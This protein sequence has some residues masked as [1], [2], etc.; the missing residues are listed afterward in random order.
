MF[1]GSPRLGQIRASFVNEAEPLSETVLASRPPFT[2]IMMPMISRPSPRALLSF[3]LAVLGCATR[4]SAVEIVAH[5]GASADA[6][7]NSLS[8]MKLAWQQNADAI[9]TDLWLSKD[10]KLIVFHDADTKRI[11]KV[12]RKI[13]DYT[14]AEAQQVDIGTWK[15]PQFAGER[16]PT[17]ESFLATIPEGKRIF[18]EIKCGPEIIPEFVRVL[19]ASGRP[20]SQLAVISF[21]Y[22]SI[23]ESKKALPELEH[24]LLADYKKDEKTGEL[25][26]LA[27]LIT[28][29]KEAKL[30]GLDLQFKWPI[31]E[32][33]VSEV[34]AAG[35]KLAAWTVDDPAVAKKLATAGVASI[36]TNKPGW[37]RE[38]LK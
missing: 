35:L 29:A 14:L 21:N 7:E 4:L 13:S 31:D 26:Q 12:N 36:T 10:G 17:L 32:A 24:Y 15:G 2:Q 27:T 20:A 30:D 19:K 1:R 3:F 18:L 16:I 28:Q 37:L 5:R 8:S 33:F 6:P 38:Q 22:D 9:E 11:G 23:R 34:K 25:P